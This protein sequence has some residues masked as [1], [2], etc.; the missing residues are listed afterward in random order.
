MKEKSQ[1]NNDIEI[2]KYEIASYIISLVATF[3]ALY[4][5]VS[6]SKNSKYADYI[7][8]AILIFNGIAILFHSFKLWERFQRITSFGK[9]TQIGAKL[10]V[11][12]LRL[13]IVAAA[14]PAIII[15][16]FS[17]LTIGRGVQTWLSGQ[18]KEAIKANSGFGKETLQ[19][20]T[21]SS[22]S[23]ILAMASDLNATASQS[24]KSPE[25]YAKYLE[26]QAQRRGFVAV[27]LFKKNGE[28]LYKV[29]RPGGVP[30]FAPPDKEDIKTADDGTVNVNIDENLIV[31]VIYKL[32]SYDDTYLYVVRLPKPGQAKLVKQAY[33][34][35]AAY[36]N[37]DKRQSQLQLIF[38]IAYLE[39]VLLVVIGASWLG[40]HSAQTIS[41]PI[42]RLVVAAE[43]VAE[44]DLNVRVIPEFKVQELSSLTTTFNRMTSE[45]QTQNMALKASRE[46]A[47]KRTQFI[48]AMLEGVTTAIVS[49]NKNGEILLANGSASKL[50]GISPENIKGK[51]S[52]LEP[53]FSNILEKLSHSDH[54]KCHIERNHDNQQQILDVRASYAG[55]DIVVTFDDISSILQ[56]Q[57]QAAWKDVARRIAHEI[58]NPLTPIQLSAERLWR[59]FSPQITKDTETY[60]KLTDT[61]IRQVGDIG[62]MVDEFSSFARMPA[63]K[64]TLCDINE[65]ARQSVF[66]QKI[67]N[68]SIDYK[69]E[70]PNEPVMAMVDKRLISQ[71]L[72][73]ILKNAAESIAQ[74]EKNDDNT[75]NEIDFVM[76]IS[77]NNVIMKIVDTG[78]GFPKNDRQR[79]LEPYMTTRAKGTGLGLAIVARIFEEH[80][81]HIKLE[82]REDNERGAC[83]KMLI[84][85][86]DNK[87]TEDTVNA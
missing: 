31:R 67:T 58:K 17:A 69:Y 79:L 50:L 20:A 72:L 81:G 36:D 1:I 33:E 5:A 75:H 45:L 87:N 30:K 41:R 64:F 60:K 52:E 2:S 16:M 29:E 38:S 74:L 34:V 26:N 35:I 59:K 47:E 78:I 28:I 43:K 61:I 19:Q 32:K 40:L 37:L 53:H 82:D 57:R 6:A 80:H 70:G 46:Q 77:N 85:L 83:V 4:F 44:G 15:A 51:L 56:A 55:D 68:A 9:N 21:D 71:A 63:P 49:L 25:Q 84:P 22:K 66:D 65:I 23:D 62:H 86:E 73:N 12:F 11:R 3:T 14:L 27:Y 24:I 18:V 42:S 8:P 7:I 13:F 54:A 39:T 48:Q 10:H 76:E